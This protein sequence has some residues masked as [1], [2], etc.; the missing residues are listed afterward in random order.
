MNLPNIT[1]V[2]GAG[3]LQRP[4]AGQ[5]HIAGLIAYMSTLP[6]G[7][8]STDR[9][10]KV[11]SLA[12]A[13]SLG[14]NLNY[15][16]A[17]APTGSY[18]VTATGSNGDTITLTHLN[19]KGATVTLGTY[20]KVA[21]DTTAA[22]VATGI[23]AAINAGTNVHGYSA[24]TSTATVN[25]TAPKFNG[26]FSGTLAATIVGTIAGTLTQ[27]ASGTMSPI[28]CLYYHVSEFFRLMPNGELYIS[29]PGTSYGSGFPEVMTL[30]N[31]ADG[32]IRQIGVMNDLSTA[33]ATSQITSLQTQATAAFNA[34]RPCVILFA[35]E[36]SGTSNLSALTDLSS[37]SSAQVAT[38]ISQDAGNVG[39]YIAT[40]TGKSLSDLGAKLG[41]LSKSKVSDSWA[42]VGAY[43]MTDG[44]ELN[45]I[46]FS[47][48]TTYTTAVNNNILN[49]L[50]TYGYSFLRKIT[51][52]TGTYNTQPNT[53][54]LESSDYRF[55]YSNRVIQKAG[56][57]E[58]LAMIPFQSSP[59]VL[60]A[61]GTLSDLTIETWKAAIGQQ[62]DVMVRN[63]ELSNYAVTI[64]PTQLVLQTNSVTIGVQLQPV[65]VADFITITNVFTI[66]IK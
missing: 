27:F 26:V 35:P 37:L 45:T 38:I 62:L 57:V 8:S 48:G 52:Y 25:I 14:I 28:A 55:L 15:V 50:A 54:T 47:N 53:A 40:S 19:V 59:V 31:F 58:R 51:D 65:G 63:G 11:N 1:I 39:K 10:K 49:Q 44:S 61:D 60:D 29:I 9:I 16:D 32:K 3:G 12:Q 5:D 36:I 2:N 34:F 6:S 64:D 22:N 21:G 66:Q 41:V 7:F 30:V 42:W 23:A 17:T 33:F 56:R 18:L 46:G 20:T 43:N 24:T 4:P 13:V